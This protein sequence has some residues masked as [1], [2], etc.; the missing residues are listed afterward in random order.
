MFAD[1]ARVAANG[2]SG[3]R[4][5]SGASDSEAV[6]TGTV[7]NSGIITSEAAVG[8]L[9][10]VV[11]E[12]G[13]A[14]AGVIN[15]SGLI[16]GVQN[17]L[18]LGNAEHELLIENA[19]SIVSDS[20]AVNL[21]GDN[22][23][24]V[25]SGD[26]VGTGDQRNGTIYLDGTADNISIVN[27]EA[28]AIDAGEGNLGDGISIQV[29]AA[30]EDAVSE[31]I[32]VTN[33]GFIA[34]RGQ[35]LF[36]DGARV[37]A[38]GSSGLR[39]VSGASDSEAVVTGTVTN[40]GIITSEAAVGFLGGVVV[41]DG[42]AFAGVIN[43][44][45]LIE[46]VQNGLYLGNAEHELL[47][48]N[49]GSIVS[50]S[51]AVNLDGDNI[52]LVN[53]G[54]IVG[55][56]DQ[57][58]GTIYLDGTADNISIVNEEASA[59]DAGEGNL[60]DGISIQVGAADEDAVSEDI[61]VTN[62]GFIA[63]R[64]Q[65]LFADGARVAA[66]GSSGLRFVSGASDSE[67]VVTGTVTNSG[68]IT[69]E[70]AVGFL[71]GVVVEDG[72]AFAGV[73]NNSG[74]IE[75]VQNGL[76]LGNAEHELLI[77][78]TGS[79]VSDSRAVNL[80]GDNI[81]LVNSGDIVGTGDQRNGTIY[82]DGTADNISIVNEETGVVDAGG[83]NS[84]SGVSVQVGADGDAQSDNIGIINDGLIQGRGT[85]NVPAG[86]RLFVGSGLDAANFNGSIINQAN[87]VIA[88]ETAAG[89]LIEEGVI[90]DGLILNEGE[91]LGGNG[92]AI[93]AAGALG[94]VNIINNGELNGNV[95]LGQGDDAF[96]QDS[97][98]ETATVSG[99]AGSDIF[100]VEAG[101]LIIE[102]FNLG[103]DTID[104]S[105]FFDSGAAAL[106]A[107]NQD[108]DA[109][110]FDLGADASLVLAGLAEADLTAG[111]FDFA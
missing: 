27:E 46:G 72:V 19:G 39:F 95:L 15:N 111:S 80:D 57:R 54:D 3:L 41:E 28:S 87:G 6:V 11:V 101:V 2:S 98:G 102:D 55:T 81:L 76:Y 37:A 49:A 22:I 82:L 1:G 34:G 69:S 110:V 94:A 93:D 42:V 33:A 4:F 77:E 61:N 38:N 75:G 67:A 32:N 66:N 88:S 78:N 71:G 48:E 45:G 20:R 100:T 50:D 43:N 92:I 26:I 99:G 97:L 31:D 44:S 40:S 7:T 107:A 65:P 16:E 10:G 14:F 23:L 59:I 64:G 30:D 21:D 12:D 84:G 47:I 8:F 96:T 24:L 9:G 35:P 18:Y 85:D 68:I 73:I 62:A 63:G 51:R 29:G 90:F 56:G 17:G 5:V 79:I 89:I 106:A 103:E 105:A 25:N 108:G 86:V 74:L 70:A 52:L 104:L 60:G 53:S 109:T 91:I 13:V 83:G 36:A 58:N